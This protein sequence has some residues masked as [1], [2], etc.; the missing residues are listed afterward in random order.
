MRHSQGCVK[1]TGEKQNQGPGLEDRLGSE[2]A[3]KV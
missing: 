1:E 2:Q 3:S